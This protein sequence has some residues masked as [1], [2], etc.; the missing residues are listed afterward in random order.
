MAMSP[1][2]GRVC[3]VCEPTVAAA[4]REA[5]RDSHLRGITDVQ[6]LSRKLAAHKITLQELCQ[7]YMASMQLPALVDALTSHQG[8]MSPLLWLSARPGELCSRQICTRCLR[9]RCVTS[10]EHLIPADP[11][12]QLDLWDRAACVCRYGQGFSRGD[13]DQRCAGDALELL[14]KRYVDD[15]AAAHS[16]E[17]LVKFEQLVEEAVDLDAVPEEYLIDANYDAKLKVWRCWASL[18]RPRPSRVPVLPPSRRR[19]ALCIK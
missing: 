16:E 7:L 18:H 17:A 13:A 9:G 11:T 15:L 5:V 8:T 1:S 12:A 10:A 14:K 2:I 4:F 3:R 19:H 6:R